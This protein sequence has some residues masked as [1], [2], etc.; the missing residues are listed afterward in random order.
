MQ[1]LLLA[2][3]L[4]CGAMASP[5]Q[6]TSSRELLVL[7]LESLQVE[8]MLP[9]LKPHLPDTVVASG[10]NQRLLVTGPEAE[11]VTVRQLV[12]ALDVAAQEYRVY[13]SRGPLNP[14]TRQASRNQHLSTARNQVTR[15]TLTQA[16][17]AYLEEGFWL[18]T[19]SAHP[20]RGESGY[21]WMSGGLWVVA[22]AQG[23][24]VVL[25][26]SSR[27]LELLPREWPGQP[28]P[29]SGE[30]LQTRLALEPGRWRTLAGRQLNRNEE[31]NRQ[32]STAGA[33]THYAVCL[34]AVDQESGCPIY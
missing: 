13:F 6:E 5:A 26:F 18:P 32:R 15:L 30:Q 4:L 10:R 9:L 12:A 22:K 11:L 14:E 28:T 17:P 29:V 33:A 31:R 7:D 16:R 19:G 23:E 1:R 24:R 3:L 21:Q 34:E 8:E 27:Q 20:W 2:F 25:E